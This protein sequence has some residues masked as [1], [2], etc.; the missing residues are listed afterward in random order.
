MPMQSLRIAVAMSDPDGL[1]RLESTISDA[2]GRC[3]TFASARQAFE[4][5][6]RERFDLLLVGWNMH[7][8]AGR[9]LL[10][11]LGKTVKEPPLVFLI[12]SRSARRNA[13]VA[14]EDGAADYVIMPD[15]LPVLRA[16]ILAAVRARQNPVDDGPSRHGNFAFDPACRCVSYRDETT[17]LRPKEFVLARMLFENLDRPLSRAGIIARIWN[18]RPDPYSRT[19][20]MH[21]SRVRNKLQLKPERGVSLKTIFGYGYRLESCS[22][23]SRHP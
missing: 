10:G 19:L 18:S 20:D 9:N 12:V 15:D 16:R 17:E 13:I 21:I 22:T 2:R 3:S 4:A 1:A 23:A 8:I 6:G 11:H 5:L 14:L 7:G